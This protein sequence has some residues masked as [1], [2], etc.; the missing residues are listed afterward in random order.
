ML[1]S[2]FSR[3]ADYLSLMRLD[4][5]I[6]IFLL[7]WPTLWGL[8]VAAEGQPT[9]SITLIFVLGT[10]LTRSGGCVLNDLADRK[11]DGHV[12]RTKN[13]PL[14]TGRVTVKEAIIIAGTCFL[15]AFFLIIGLS[16]LTMALAVVA[17]FLAGSYPF[18]KRWIRIPQAYLGLAFSFGSLMAF[19]AV[20][21]DLPLE[22]WLIFVAGCFW[23]V[24]YDTEYAMVDKEDDLKINIKTSA[25]TFGKYDTLAVVI[26]YG[27]M[28]FCLIILGHL[29]DFGMFYYLGLL[30]A[31]IMMAYHY[32]LIRQTDPAR[33][34]KAFLHNA[35]VGAAIFVG[36]ALDYAVAM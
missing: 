28:Q 10:I 17:V 2:F 34:F 32:L 29:L 5:P 31:L 24:A 7:L 25:I 14:V 18:M 3:R 4:K 6:G 1:F 33:C 9:L 22:A 16:W 27:I 23:A 35:W 20:R 15:L 8:W 30:V 36:I 26:C 11:Y 19:A 13:R 21:N 12:R